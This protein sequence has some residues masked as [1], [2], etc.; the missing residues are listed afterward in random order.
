VLG[1]LC[2]RG[3]ILDALFI[4]DSSSKKELLAMESFKGAPVLPQSCCAIVGNWGML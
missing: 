3:W 1:P 4:A 2:G